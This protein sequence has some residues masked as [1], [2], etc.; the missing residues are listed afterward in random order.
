MT[1]NLK[2]IDG[3]PVEREE[4]PSSEAELAVLMKEAYA[5]EHSMAAIGGGTELH[6]GNPPRSVHLGLHIG[7]MGGV[8]EYEPG[9]L[10]VTA[11][12]G[13][14]LRELQATL[15]RENQF[16]P[17]DPPCPEAA[18]IGGIVAA[19]A[20]GS[21]RFRYG[22]VRDLLIGIRTVL[23]DGT[24]THAG[25][26]LVKNVSGYDMCK[27]YAGS[28][29]T[30]GIFSELTFKVQP[31]S[32]ASAVAILGYADMRSALE[33]TQAFLHADLAPDA[34]EILNGA[35]YESL[36]GPAAAHARI[37]LLRF[38]ET[39]AAVRWQVDRLRPLVGDTGGTL[40]GVMDTGETAEYW[41][42][43]AAARNAQPSENGLWLKCASQYQNACDFERH[44]TEFGERLDARVRLYCHAGA[45]V[46]YGRY[47][48]PAAGCVPV[49]V[50]REVAALRRLI[51]AAGG[52]LV[53]EK[54]PPDVKTNVEVWGYN[55]PA[56][57]LMRA[58][59]KQFDPKGL[60]N[61]GRFVG[62]I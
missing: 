45:V 10:T 21:I 47:D 44:M 39:D 15:R 33:A 55:A 29:G 35:A 51:G 28:L 42:R 62:G 26:K 43:V 3:T 18:T 20:S 40:L 58:I 22:T 17:L 12:A 37:L 6:L 59:K 57:A 14:T 54:A 38:G 13:T 23:A 41:P 5:H 27:L 61:P 24:A 4:H 48:W 36:P 30:L 46:I 25:G 19:N 2:C 50:A 11:R 8:I 9:N 34:M 52:S 1:A 49:P 53:I 31:E 56:L 32:E 16:L 7:G 60:L